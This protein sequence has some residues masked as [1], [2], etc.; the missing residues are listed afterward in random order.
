MDSWEISEAIFSIIHFTL[1]I[2]NMSPVPKTKISQEEYLVL[3]RN[4]PE[5]NEFYRGEIFAMA[6]TWN[7]HNIITGNIIGEIHAFLKGKGCTIYPSDMRLHIPEI[8]FYTYPDVM[9]VCGPK[10]FLD[11]K[12]D[13][14]LNSGIIV[15]VLSPNTEGYDRGEKFRLYRSIASLQEYVLVDSRS[16]TL[17][18][19]ARSVAGSWVLTDAQGL[20][21]SIL[22][23]TIE[24]NLKLEDVY[25]GVE[26]IAVWSSNRTS[27]IHRK[28]KAH[29]FRF[30][31][32]YVFNLLRFRLVI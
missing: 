8:S 5:K 15:E 18:K 10:Q 23:Q 19:Y 12:K 16:Y 30:G 20:Q 26:D 14:L 31:A 32:L 1:F 9:V 22:L 24:Y 11:N 21:A 17:E 13:T 29:Q 4:S 6:G 28:H 27:L 3:E 25:A 2:K 7:N